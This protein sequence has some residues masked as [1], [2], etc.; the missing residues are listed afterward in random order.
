M[1]E[2]FSL[3]SQDETHFDI[4]YKLVCGYNVYKT[5]V[6]VVPAEAKDLT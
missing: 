1:A 3:L 2:A 4:V 6:F 5:N